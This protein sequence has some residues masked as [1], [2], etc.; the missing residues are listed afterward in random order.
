MKHLLTIA[1][2]LALSSPVVAQK[3][4]AAPTGHGGRWSG[5]CSPCRA[6]PGDPVPP[7][8]GGSHPTQGGRG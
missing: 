5:P 1:A 4:P 2:I 7:G 3:A 6:A 8:H